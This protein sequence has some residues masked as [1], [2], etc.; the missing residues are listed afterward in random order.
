MQGSGGGAGGGAGSGPPFALIIPGRRMMTDFKQIQPKRALINIPKPAEIREFMFCLTR[1]VPQEAGVALYYSLPPFKDWNYIGAVTMAYPSR[2]FHAPWKHKIPPNTPG[3][4]IG[5][6]LEPIASL[7]QKVD[8][9]N[10][11]QERTLDSAQ[12]IAKNLYEFMASFNK[13]ERFTHLPKD[14]MVLPTDVVDKWFKKFK[15]KHQRDPYFWMKKGP[16]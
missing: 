7:K 16:S 1:P 11:E 8:S 14:V 2:S 9:D 13:S 5:V 3:L 10:K 12:G 6:N 15:A 4:R